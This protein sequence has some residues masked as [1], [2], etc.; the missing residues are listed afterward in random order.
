MPMSKKAHIPIHN[1]NRYPLLLHGDWGTGK[2]TFAGQFENPYFLMFEKNDEYSFHLNNVLNWDHCVELINEFMLGD[3]DRKTIIFDN[4]EKFYTMASEKF[5]N[6]WNSRLDKDKK[7][8][9]NLAGAG[10][11][12][13]YDAVERM[14][15]IVVNPLIMSDKYNVIFIAHSESKPFETLSGDVFQKLTPRLPNKR[16]RSFF[17]TAV[18]NIFY[19]YYVK[20]NLYIRIVAN[21]F[22]VAKNRGEGHFRTTKGEQV[23]NIPCGKHETQTYKYVQGAYFN[24]L[25][26][27]FK[28]I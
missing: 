20:D 10:Y 4:I 11:T 21:D 28:D 15:N 5:M 17:L 12:N 23:I 2:T 7:P 1:L 16:A 9:I 22:I 13:G 18:S 19:H 25:K 3:H 26:N 8:I 27:S 6:D 24:K 14:L